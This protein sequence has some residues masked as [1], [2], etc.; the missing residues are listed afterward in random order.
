MPPRAGRAAAAGSGALIAVVDVHGHQVGDMWAVDAADHGRWLS[1]GHTR[2]RCERLFPAL[3]EE[4]R[5]QHG[6][7][8][9]RLV[10]DTSPS[11]HDMLFPACD[12]A[13]YASRGLPLDPSRRPC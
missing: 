13:M 10:R 7:P 12:P 11:V 4:F 8:I 2:D 5:D 1:P 6:E 9:L 3:G